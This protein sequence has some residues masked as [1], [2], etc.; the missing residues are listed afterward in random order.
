M[1]D[2]RLQ[3]SS[4][5]E[6]QT[7]MLQ[8]PSAPPLPPKPPPLP[9]E[10]A[11]DSAPAVESTMLLDGDSAAEAARLVLGDRS[12]QKGRAQAEE[13]PLDEPL[14]EME[15]PKHAPPTDGTVV[16]DSS[17]LAGN[18]DAPG[19]TMHLDSPGAGGLAGGTV[20]ITAEPKASPPRKKPP[21]EALAGGTMV[22][23]PRSG[24]REAGP[25][26]QPGGTVVATPGSAGGLSRMAGTR[27][28]VA[29]Y[30]PSGGVPMVVWLLVVALT[31][32]A[33]VMVGL[34]L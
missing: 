32:V 1:A 26:G 8:R 31:A 27:S 29:M 18:V 6:Q 14:D 25:S 2:E 13:E 19:G 28:T 33:G 12:P 30:P 21:A 7:L 11:R 16:L 22:V 4:F 15:V 9:G 17:A 5:D 20:A 34:M 24:G 3:D 10:S 23:T